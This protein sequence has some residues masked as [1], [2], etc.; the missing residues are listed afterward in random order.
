M[1]YQR[2]LD[3]EKRLADVLKLVSM[4]QFSTPMLAARLEVSIPT[5]SRDITAL[6]QR[7]HDIIARRR[8]DGSWGYSLAV[9]ARGT[10]NRHERIRGRHVGIAFRNNRDESK[11]VTP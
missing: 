3:I 2:S 9:T 5:V 4:G 6:R 8:A 1:L 11:A 7:G 10:A